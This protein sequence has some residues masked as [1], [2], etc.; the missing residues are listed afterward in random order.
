MAPKKKNKSNKLAN[1]SE[2]E[3]LRYLQHK[4]TME[5]E[6]HRRKQQIIATYMN[7]NLH[8]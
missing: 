6:A 5:E 4:A 2:E 8:V 1:M 7:V 3:R